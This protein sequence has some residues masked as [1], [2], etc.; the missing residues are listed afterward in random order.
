[1]YWFYH[2]TRHVYIIDGRATYNKF[3]KDHMD[4]RIRYIFECEIKYHSNLLFP[5]P[6][7]DSVDNGNALDDVINK[8]ASSTC[9]IGLED[10]MIN[11]NSMDAR[12][13]LANKLLSLMNSDTFNDRE[14][15]IFIEVI[16]NQV[17]HEQ[18]G[19]QYGISRT[20][21]TQIFAKTKD[22]LYKKIEADAEIWQM[23]DDADVAI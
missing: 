11:D 21:V 10:G 5:D 6:Y 18:L 12:H 14:R 13:K 15:S 2:Y 8:Y 4:Q 16:C 22:K 17:T 19:E 7:K 23:L 1:M 9:D 3:I 20:R